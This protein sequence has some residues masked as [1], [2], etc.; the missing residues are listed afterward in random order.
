MTK[1]GSLPKEG[2]G[3]EG[4]DGE[5]QMRMNHEGHGDHGGRSRGKANSLM[6]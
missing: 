6:V 3:E 5:L 1:G 4:E 2:K